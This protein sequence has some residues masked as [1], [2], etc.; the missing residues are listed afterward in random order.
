ME[1]MVWVGE[2]EMSRAHILLGIK[3]HGQTRL[4]HLALRTV[5]HSSDIR[6]PTLPLTHIPHLP[7]SRDSPYP[8]PSGSTDSHTPP[9]KIHRFHR[10]CRLASSFNCSCTPPG[11][12]Q[13]SPPPTCRDPEIPQTLPLGL[14]L[15]LLLG[16]VDGPAL[17]R[18]G[19][20]VERG[21]C[22]GGVCVWAGWGGGI[23][24]HFSNPNYIG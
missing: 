16:W 18:L 4:K 24:V 17:V 21:L 1:G 8:H 22:G 5:W 6:S 3:G 19:V 13:R 12:I 15:Q 9:A 2:E 7:G 14:L 23:P 10:P 11:Q 20:G